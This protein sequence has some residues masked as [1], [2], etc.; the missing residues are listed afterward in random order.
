MWFEGPSGKIP[1]IGVPS[2]SALARTAIIPAAAYN[3]FSIERDGGAWR[4][5]QTVR[6]LAMTEPLK[7]WGTPNYRNAAAA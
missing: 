4:C 2:A 3:L 1:A 7:S 6:G 5:E